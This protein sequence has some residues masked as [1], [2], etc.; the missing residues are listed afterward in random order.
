[1]FNNSSRYAQPHGTRKFRTIVLFNDYKTFPDYHYTADID[2]HLI[3]TN[4]MLQRNAEFWSGLRYPEC[5]PHLSI[6]TLVTRS[7]PTM[8]SSHLPLPPRSASFTPPLL[9]SDVG[10]ASD[11]SPSTP[12]E[13]AAS[14]D[15]GNMSGS[16]SHSV[17]PANGGSNSSLRRRR[18]NLPK[19]VTAFLRN[20]LVQHKRHPYPTEDEKIDLARRTALT[21]NQI[22]NWFIN[23]RR[24]IL[25]P[26]LRNEQMHAASVAKKE[27]VNMHDYDN[28]IP[29][30]DGKRKNIRRLPHR[31][32]RSTR[33]TYRRKRAW[34][35]SS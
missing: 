28:G 22:S 26:I 9:H 14:L 15:D 33:E 4:E 23:A 17:K 1:M 34:V 13:Q 11:Y 19:N 16:D 10:S 12:P 2:S 18:G 27:H 8:P 35:T 30:D 6:D 29:F 7:S 21:V 32:P 25:Q 5:R 24:R 31:S 3:K 20:W